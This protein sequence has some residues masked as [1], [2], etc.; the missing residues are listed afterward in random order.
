VEIQVGIRLELETGPTI[1]KASK[2][3][4]ASAQERAREGYLLKSV[5]HALDPEGGDQF[6]SLLCLYE[7]AA[8]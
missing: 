8:A 3:V 4:L 6:W 2:D 7:K 5:S 1:Q